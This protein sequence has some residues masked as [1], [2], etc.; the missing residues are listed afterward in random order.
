MSCS[1]CMDYKPS[2][3]DIFTCPVCS[4]RWALANVHPGNY[5]ET[6]ETAEHEKQRAGEFIRSCKPRLQGDRQ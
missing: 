3:E 6:T 2:Q 5:W 4:Q 1:K